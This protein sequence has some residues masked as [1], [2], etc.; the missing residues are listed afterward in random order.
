MLR[1]RNCSHASAFH[2]RWGR[3]YSVGSMAA[4]EGVQKCLG[5]TRGRPQVSNSLLQ[6]SRVFESEPYAGISLI[7][8]VSSTVLNFVSDSRQLQ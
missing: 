6:A 5:H 4:T 2:G 3:D 1:G 8:L 7:L